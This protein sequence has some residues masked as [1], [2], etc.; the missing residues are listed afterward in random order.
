MAKRE[1]NWEQL[2]LEFL[3][4][5]FL[6]AREFFRQKGICITPNGKQ[7]TGTANKHVKSWQSEKEQFLRDQTEKAKQEVIDS[8]INQKFIKNLIMGKRD[9]IRTV[10]ERVEVNE[11]NL[12]MNELKIALDIVKRELGEPLDISRNENRNENITL[13]DFLDELKKD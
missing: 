7:L 1:Y 8:K 10:L 9:I 5:E 11:K 6:E 4:S 13:D 12:N 3:N 2:K